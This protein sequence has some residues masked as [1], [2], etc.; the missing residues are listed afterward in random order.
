MF[1]PENGSSVRPDRMAEEFAPMAMKG[2]LYNIC[3]EGGR[4][5]HGAEETLKSIVAGDPIM[6][7]HKGVDAIE[8]IPRAKLFIAANNLFNARDMSEGFLQRFVFLPF[9]NTFTPGD[10]TIIERLKQ[11]LP[12]IFNWCLEGYRMLM[13]EGFIECE[14]QAK[15]RRKFVEHIEPLRVFLRETFTGDFNHRP[16][17]D[18]VLYSEYPSL[19]T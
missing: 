1:G 2:K 16:L 15:Y 12:G 9:E 14:I 10:P 3:F 8:F 19:K 5:L 18:K 4:Y 6:A 17:G 11:N 7:S 13:K